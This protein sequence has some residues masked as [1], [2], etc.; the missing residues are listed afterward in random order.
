LFNFRYGK[1]TSIVL[2]HSIGFEIRAGC[3]ATI[4][5][6]IQQ[7]YVTRTKEGTGPR[8]NVKKGD[9]NVPYRTRTLTVK[10]LDVWNNDQRTDKSMNSHRCHRPCLNY[11]PEQRRNY[12]RGRGIGG[13]GFTL[14]VS[15]SVHSKNSARLGYLSNVNGVEIIRWLLFD[16]RWR[17]PVRG[18]R[19]A[20]IGIFIKY[21][22]R[23]FFSNR[24]H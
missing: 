5:A 11:S 8:P 6:L 18:K 20:E 7:R 13:R 14:S 15:R 23:I 10:R 24:R 2:F 12:G 1:K 16:R 22:I 19:T 21:F 4:A 9:R 3:R 17:V